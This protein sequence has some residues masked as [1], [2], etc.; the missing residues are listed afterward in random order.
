MQQLAKLERVLDLSKQIISSQANLP[1]LEMELSLK[2]TLEQPVIK[3]VFKGEHGTIGY[4]VVNVLVTRFLDSFGFS[5]KPSQIMIEGITVDTLE[6]FEYESLDDIILFF[7]MARQGAFGSTSKGVDS[8]L[9][10]GQW[11]PMYLDRKADLRDLEYQKNKSEMNSVIVPM[12][13]EDYN[14]MLDKRNPKKKIEEAQKKVDEF[15]KNFDKQMLEDTI[16][17][18]SKNP[19]WKFYTELLK[20]KRLTIR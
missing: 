6:K 20:R 18:W 1:M 3:S 14:K 4:S 11:F 19:Q 12:S 7:K 17:E 13:I 8:N 5:T 16:T 10:F 9:I 15:T 2:S